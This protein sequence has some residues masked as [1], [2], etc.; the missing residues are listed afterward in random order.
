LSHIKIKLVDVT[1]LAHYWGACEPLI[2]AGLAPSD[3]ESSAQ[4]VHSDLQEQRTQLIVGLDQ[5]N[6]VLAA[7]VVQF[8]HYPNYKV[9]HVYSIGGRGVIENAVHWASIKAWMKQ[10]GASK[11][12]GVCKPAQARLWQKLG[13]IDTYHMVRQDL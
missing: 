7:M 3:G 13:F 11:V 5:Q 10:H 6:N 2:A 9:A 4:H 12:Q 1:E 8:I